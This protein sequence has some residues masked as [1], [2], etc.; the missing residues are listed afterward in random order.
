[1]SLDREETKTTWKKSIQTRNEH[2]LKLSGHRPFCFKGLFI[3]VGTV[4]CKQK[5][6]HGGQEK[7]I[8]F[9]FRSA[10]IIQNMFNIL[11]GS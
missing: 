1:M 10:Y 5:G 3:P 8:E 6:D 11:K 9:C 4:G 2:T 7:G